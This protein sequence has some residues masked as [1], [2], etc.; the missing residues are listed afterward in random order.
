MNEIDKILSLKS[1]KLSPTQ[2]R[3]LISEPFLRDMFFKRSVV[4]LANHN[5]EGSFGVILNKPV[6]FKFNEV[7]QGFPQ[8]EA[9]IYMGGPV[10]TE[11]IF[12]IHTMGEWIDE[13]HEIMQ[14]LYWGGNI[15]TVK[16]LM[17]DGKLDK[18]QIKFFLGYSGWAP[19]QLAEEL[20]KYSWVITDSRP[21]KIMK[22]HSED[23]WKNIVMSLGKE[24][25][26]WTR[27]PTAPQMN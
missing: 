4:M 12:F 1:S 8:F 6:E 17:E 27:F 11:N 3:L 26:I 5:N 15:E 7:V 18:N 25:E 16:A 13:S 10:S 22:P 23:L 14:G 19:N 24:F 9:P 20:K 2:G 21:S